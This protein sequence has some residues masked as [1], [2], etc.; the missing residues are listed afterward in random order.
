M[1]HTKIGQVDPEPLLSIAIRMAPL[2]CIAIRMALGL[3]R[4]VSKN[5]SGKI[6]L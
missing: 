4:M 3:H 1:P 5:I 6:V 2:F